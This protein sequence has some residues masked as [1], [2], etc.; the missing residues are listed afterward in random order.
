[1]EQS[2]KRV[3]DQYIIDSIENTRM[4]MVITL[5]LVWNP[6]FHFPAL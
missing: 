1:M 4:V 5:R 6:N 2:I 3:S